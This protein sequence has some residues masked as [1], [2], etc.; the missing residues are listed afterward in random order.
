MDHIA[1]AERREE[2]RE[3]GVCMKWYIIESKEMLCQAM[4][5]PVWRSHGPFIQIRMYVRINSIY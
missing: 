2:G 4:D 1:T 3:I 5:G